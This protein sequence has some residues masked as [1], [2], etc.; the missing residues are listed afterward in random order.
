[1]SA[2]TS[3]TGAAS[4]AGAL[5]LRVVLVDD[6]SLFRQ[7][8]A[9][10]LTAAGLEIVG[11]LGGADALPALIRQVRPHAVVLDVRMP[12]THTDE[13][14]VTAQ[15]IRREWPHVGVLVLSTYAEAE[16]ARRLLQDG[17]AGLGYLLKDR[18]NDVP[19][20]IDAIARVAQG[21]TAVDADIVSQLITGSHGRSS[22]L[23]SLSEREL[24]VLAL[25]A[26]GK[27]NAGI[28]RQLHLSPR[29]VE[30]H[31]AAV[32]TKLPLQGHDTTVNRRVLAVLAYLQVHHSRP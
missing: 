25:M 10:L 15:G 18:V 22:A 31:V 5:P 17:A 16:W 30:A 21:G 3:P 7:G 12:P 24:E 29:T 26:Q 14:I 1:M 8:L 23:G 9:G 28:G 4:D 2:P 27:S 13:G 19:S 20:L 32:F 6:S 11:Q